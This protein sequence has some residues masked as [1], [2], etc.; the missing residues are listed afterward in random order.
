MICDGPTYGPDTDIPDC[1]C[2]PLEPTEDAC[3]RCWAEA[4]D[5]VD[6][7]HEMERVRW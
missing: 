5:E 7:R 4:E 6:Y 2:Y 1:P 3:M